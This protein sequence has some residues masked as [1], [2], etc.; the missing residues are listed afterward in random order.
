MPIDV[1]APAGADV[2]A[3]TGAIEAGDVGTSADFD[4]TLDAAFSGEVGDA[5]TPGAED[6]GPEVQVA[7]E[8][9]SEEQ[10]DASQQQPEQQQPEPAQS[11]LEEGV[12]PAGNGKGFYVRKDRFN[13]FQADRKFATQVR[14]VVPDL[15]SLQT[16]RQNASDF[17]LMHQDFQYGGAEDMSEFAKHWAEVSPQRFPSAAGAMIDQ[18]RTVAPQAYQ[19]F[20]NIAVGEIIDSLYQQAVQSDD[21]HLLYA[22]QRLEFEQTSKR[23]GKGTYRTPDQIKIQAPEDARLRSIESRERAL[24]Q[25]TNLEHDQYWQNTKNRITAN[26]ET[27]LN[28]AIQEALK[29]GQGRFSE[30]NLRAISRDVKAEVDQ[31]LKGDLEWS[32]N[33]D[34]QMRNLE[35]QIRTALKGNQAIDTTAQAKAYVDAYIAKARGVISRVAREQLGEATAK[36]VEQNQQQHAKLAAGQK[37]GIAAPSKPA[38][39]RKPNGG[40]FDAA[41]ESAWSN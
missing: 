19:G 27:A 15:E 37:K 25:R 13:E 2:S 28:A 9:P 1:A 32:R 29:P 16:L 30:Q 8:T 22:A 7:E 36:A 34:I 24:Q 11:E 40:G 3:G 6:P 31:A 23:G 14:D 33:Y 20:V 41:F 17:D 39:I 21:P 18:L 4:S 26:R 12:Q 35:S 38:G 5:V 10:P